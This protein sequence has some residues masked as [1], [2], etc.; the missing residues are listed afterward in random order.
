M[1]IIDNIFILLSKL[2][3][4]VFVIEIFIYVV[5]SCSTKTFKKYFKRNLTFKTIQLLIRLLVFKFFAIYDLY[6]RLM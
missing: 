1:K 2:F 3:I 4:G 6:G 5:G